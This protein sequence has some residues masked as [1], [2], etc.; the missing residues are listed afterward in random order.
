VIVGRTLG[1]GD[2]E[3]AIAASWRMIGKRSGVR[4]GRDP[5]RAG[6]TRFLMWSMLASA[7]GVVVPVTLAALHFDWGIV[8]VWA[9]LAG[10]IFARLATCGT[11]FVRGRWAVTGAP[12]MA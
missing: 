10:L 1:A 4:V 11:R 3:G 9:G 7:I 2:A 5:H 8:G 12:R 6:D